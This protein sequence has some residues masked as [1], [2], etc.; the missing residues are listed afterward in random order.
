M[1]SSLGVFSCDEYILRISRKLNIKS[2]SCILSWDNSTT[3][4]YPGA[5]PDMIYSWT[6]IMKEELINFSDCNRNIITTAGCHI[7]IIIIITTMQI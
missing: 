4:G 3:R 5:L 1:T 2:C 7:L 6:D